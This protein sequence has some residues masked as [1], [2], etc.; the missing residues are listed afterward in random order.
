MTGYLQRIASGV[1]HSQRAI[2]P[3]VGSLWMPQRN[4]DPSEQFSENMA[5][6]VSRRSTQSDEQPTRS[7][8][9]HIGT[10]QES[11]TPRQDLSARR[12]DTSIPVESRLELEHP[13]MV[14]RD[15]IVTQSRDG[16]DAD[17][18]AP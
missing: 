11:N 4:I 5:P 6:I 14:V 16:R 18:A 17:A 9:A 8:L 15:V 2:H 12:Q 3:A 13:R 10:E 7:A 1:L